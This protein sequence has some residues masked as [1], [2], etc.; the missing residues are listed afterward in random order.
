MAYGTYE[1]TN[2]ATLKGWHWQMVVVDV[3]WG[4]VPDRRF[5]LVGGYGSPRHQLIA[6]AK[7]LIFTGVKYLLKGLQSS[8][9]S[10]AIWRPS[11]PS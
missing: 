2:L 10:P 7:T 8:L 6:M 3:S 1:F 5:G 4:A 11:R 9:R